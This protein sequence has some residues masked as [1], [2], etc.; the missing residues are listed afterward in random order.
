MRQHV[1]D[2][3]EAV[4]R[5]VLRQHLLH[6]DAN[7]EQIAD[8]VLVFDAVQPPQ[9]R[10]PP[11]GVGLCQRIAQPR[12]EFPGSV[13]FGPGLVLGGHLAAGDAIV[14]SNPA[15]E[16]LGIGQ[17]GPEPF[18]VEPPFADFSGMTT[19]TMF[20]EEGS[21]GFRPGRVGVHLPG[22]SRQC[23]DERQRAE[24][25]S[26][27]LHAIVPFEEEDQAAVKSA[28]AGIV[29]RRRIVNQPR[30]GRHNFA[31]GTNQSVGARYW[32]DVEMRKAPGGATI[33]PGHWIPSM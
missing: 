11:G 17:I 12:Q 23:Q 5:R 6:I 14:N 2:R 21:E 33:R 30:Q 20:L 26:S 31:S 7:A 18:Q 27:S 32:C 16:Q 8:R 9:H 22:E 4:G 3:V 24:M 29:S 28:H 15:P 25:E 1:A 13:A 19:E 10:L